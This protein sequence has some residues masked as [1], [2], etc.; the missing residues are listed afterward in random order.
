MIH[1]VYTQTSSVNLTS[2]ANAYV[3][4]SSDQ[5]PLIKTKYLSEFRTELEKAKVR[6]NLGIADDASLLWG[7]IDGVI[8]DQKDLINFIDTKWEYSS[9]LSDEIIDIKSGLDYAIKYVSTFK[10]DSDTI[11]KCK[12]DIITITDII[13]NQLQVHLSDHDK[14]IEQIKTDIEEI[15]KAIEQLNQDLININVDPNIENWISNKQSDTI[16]LS[17]SGIIVNVLEDDNNAIKSENGL[18]VKDFS[19]DIQTLQSNQQLHS[20]S[21]SGLQE[22]LNKY[23]SSVPVGTTS[24]Y[25]IGG[26]SSGTTVDNL[27]GKNISEIIDAILFP[28]YVEELRYPT[29]YYSN[30]ATVVKV[31]SPVEYPTLTFVQNHGGPEYPYQRS[32]VLMFNNAIVEDYSNLGTHTFKGTVHYAEGNRLINN[33]GEV[34]DSYVPEGSVSTTLDVVTTYPF[35]IGNV[36]SVTEFPT[37][38][39]FNVNSGDLEFELSGKAVI[40]LPGANTTVSKFKLEGVSGF[41]DVNLDENAWSQYEQD[42][43]GVPY[44]V[45][46]KLDAYANPVLHQ[47]NFKLQQ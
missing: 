29:V 19:E 23:K 1:P 27:N 3:V 32:N 5:T 22:D 46:E 28:A 12:Q 45:Y 10:S 31:G 44:R 24:P 16:K 33:R 40:K 15:E 34:T 35:Y 20:D 42:I 8:E 38:I 13:D 30:I 25:S 26:I 6:K 37:L 9:D 14:D 36:D 39:P 2:N 17:E 43:N 47:I 7:N 11:E 21:I 18:F 41:M 4:M